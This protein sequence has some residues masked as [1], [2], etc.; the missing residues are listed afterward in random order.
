MD[1]NGET[2]TVEYL[3][4][5]MMIQPDKMATIDEEHFPQTDVETNEEMLKSI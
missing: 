2:S 4:P 5:K 1:T 3:Q